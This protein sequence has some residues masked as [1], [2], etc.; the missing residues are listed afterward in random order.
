[1]VE[2]LP[3]PRDRGRP[4]YC[5]PTW[6]T[7]R[8]TKSTMLRAAGAEPTAFP[9]VPDDLDGIHAALETATAQ[10]DLTLLSGGSSVGARDYTLDALRRLGADILAH[11]VAISPGKPTILGRTGG[12]PVLGLPGQVASAQVVML[13]FG[14][15]LVRHLAGDTVA[16]DREPATFPAELS[17]N[18]ASKQGREDHVPLFQRPIHNL[19]KANAGK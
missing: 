6:P 9:L 1:M 16:F 4:T 18:V 3:A 17:R 13:I 8:R 5:L 10:Y 2:M 14:L 15:P 7:D 11:G 12:K 19:W